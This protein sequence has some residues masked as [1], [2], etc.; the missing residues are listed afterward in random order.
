MLLLLLRIKISRSTSL[1]QN[2]RNLR[3][4]KITAYTVGTGMFVV[5]SVLV[6]LSSGNELV[7]VASL[8]AVVV[9]IGVFVVA[10]L[11][12]SSDSQEILLSSVNTL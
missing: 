6:I 10:L 11:L 5:P 12:I 4:S 3:P 7:M 8:F 1:Q 2:L 9:G